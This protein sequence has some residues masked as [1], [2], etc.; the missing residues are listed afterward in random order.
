[1]KVKHVDFIEGR[2]EQD[3]R[4][5][6][7]KFSK[8]FYT[9]FFQIGDGV[10]QIFRDWVTF[11]K[12]EKLWGNDDPL[13]PATKVAP[14]ADR[15]FAAVGL[16]RAHWSRASPIRGVFK[17]AFQEAGLPYFHPHSFR[18]TLGDIGLKRCKSAEEFKAWSQ[19]L[20]HDN[21]LTTL[22]NYGSVSCNRQAEIMRS[23]TSDRKDG[24]SDAEAIA[25]AVCRK[26]KEE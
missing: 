11:L 8:T 1:M 5:V 4:E 10:L 20:G 24:I 15:Q 19:N 21:V 2:V 25:E 14:G 6:K 23:L 13:F 16:E 26:M 22:Q 7:T 18:R 12:T 3:A 9:Y 17:K